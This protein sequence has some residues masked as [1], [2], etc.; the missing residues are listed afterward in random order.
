MSGA[1][2]RNGNRSA[3]GDNEQKSLEPALRHLQ[4][5]GVLAFLFRK[6]VERSRI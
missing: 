4:C 3:E 6:S 5:Q 2:Q 1:K